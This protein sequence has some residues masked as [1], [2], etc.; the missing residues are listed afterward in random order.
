MLVTQ[1]AYGRKNE[2]LRLIPSGI[3]AS[4]MTNDFIRLKCA[5][6]LSPELLL[7]EI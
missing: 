3:Y 7:G 4:T 6:R 1:L 2:L 5:V